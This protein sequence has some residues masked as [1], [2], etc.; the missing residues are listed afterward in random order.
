M[1]TMQ[2]RK[3]LQGIKVYSP[4]KPVE[5]VKRELGLTQVYKLA[6]NE[7]PFPPLF[8]G[9]VFRREL[10]RVQQ[11]PEAGCFYLRRAL[12]KKHRI[13][14]EQIVFGNGSDELIVMALRAFVSSGEEVV[15]AQPTF[16]VY[17]IQAAVQGARITR[18]PL[19]GF[20]YDLEAMSRAAGPRTKIIFVANPDNPSGT[21][22]TH[23][24]VKKFLK[25]IPKNTLV[26]MDEAYFEFAPGDFPKTRELLKEFPNL[27][28]TRTFSKAYG[29]AGLRIGYGIMSSRIAAALQKVRE[30]FN[31]NRLAQAA[32]VEA[33]KNKEYL[34]KV[35]THTKKEKK[36]FYRQFE[37][38]GVEFIESA[39]NFVLV[40]WKRD[41]RKVYDFLLRRGII[42]R[43][44][45]G[46]GWNNFF[47]V[48]VGLHKENEK[49]IRELRRFLQEERKK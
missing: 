41:T 20:K 32:A 1:Y 11:Y 35:L 34:K 38:L 15:V 14:Q 49:F 4:G 24:E 2:T 29:L 45:Q 25:M 7:N 18:I 33:L 23:R 44:L 12:A 46:W 16:L 26:F 42:V 9:P 48:T 36:Y 3:Q 17:E 47:R 31:V 39:T 37:E 19:S 5:E 27:L 30:P 8:L 22:C 6:S 10:K 28:C 43:Q 21:Y 40:N 13:A